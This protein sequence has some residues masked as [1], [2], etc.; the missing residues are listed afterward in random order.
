MPDPIKI[1]LPYEWSPR[2]YQMALW[3]Y[4]KAGGTRAVVCAHR[5]WGKDEVSLHHTA[6]AMHRRVGN[7]GHM[8]PEYAQ[9]R[10]AIWDAVNP[11][12]GKK[13]IDEAFP[14]FI[15]KKTID[16]EMKIVCLNGSTW[17]VLGSD[18][19][20]ALMGTSYAGIV[21][22]EEALSNPNAWAYLS[23]ILRENGGWALFIST[24]RGHNHFEHLVN[25]GLR[26][27]AAYQAGSGATHWFAEISTIDQTQVLTDQELQEELRML[28][29]LHGDDYGYA[30][31]RQ[32]WY[33]SFDAAIPGSIWGDCLRKLDDGGKILDFPMAPTSP[34]YTAWDLGRTDDTSIWFY[35]YH[36]R[37]IDVI[38]HH[39][40]SLKDIPFYMDLLE[41]KRKEHG[42]TY[43]THYLPHD[44]R[45]RTLAAGGKSILQQCHDAAKK[46]TTLGRFQ[47]GKRLDVQEG[48]QAARSTFPHCRFHAT[49]CAKGLNSLRQ[50]HR[51]WDEDKRKFNDT[52][53]HDWSS[54]DADSFR[55]LSLSWKFADPLKPEAPLMARL[56]A[57]SVTHQTMGA[58]RE[59]HFKSRRRERS[60]NLTS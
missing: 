3:E 26:E 32:E 10:K 16:D 46:N 41:A 39:S 33:C 18:N 30:V 13:R 28:Q 53:A 47:I 45:P 56:Q 59:A 51:E 40:S 8:L 36:G 57:Q 38:D 20:N 9:G 29:D 58:M 12:S 34:V 23:P 24:A 60:M 14:L 1:T 48:I 44:A 49:R 55:Y 52:P 42:L 22:S 5:R 4:L 11:H 54:H 19:Y 50:Y 27:Q 15:R 35:Q 25:T 17:Q 37:G 2:P 43:G 6:C 7:Y 31:W 21:K